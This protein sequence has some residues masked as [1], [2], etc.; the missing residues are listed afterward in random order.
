MKEINANELQKLI[1]D[2]IKIS[3][4]KIN[5]VTDVEIVNCFSENITFTNCIFSGDYM[6]FFTQKD[7]DKGRKSLSFHSCKFYIE[8]INFTSCNFNMILLNGAV[9][10]GDFTITNVDVNSLIFKNLRAEYLE[11][12]NST[13]NTRF[14]L[15]KNTNIG[16]VNINGTNFKGSVEISNSVFREINIEGA[17]CFKKFSFNNNVINDYFSL[18]SNTFQLTNF[19]SNT[20]KSDGDHNC[21]SVLKNT[22]HDTASFVN[23]QASESDL[24][25][26]DCTFNQFTRFN[27]SNFKLLKVEQV[28]FNSISSFQDVVLE[29]IYIERTNFEK[30]SFFDDISISKI[31]LCNKRTLKSIKHE[32][33]R[34]NNKIDFDIFKSYELN[35][36]RKELLKNGQFWYN[37]KDAFILFVGNLFSENGMN[38][39]RALFVTIIGS[40][41]FYT[42]FYTV[43]YWKLDFLYIILYCILLVGY[44]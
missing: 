40:L 11:I 25:L 21:L 7:K 22:F 12:N 36:H 4:T 3:H 32:L 1:N 27:L 13:I 14:I 24:L 39:I 2:E 29:R 17:A 34:T 26:K 19:D 44:K 18:V 10:S 31:A 38:W 8:G 16:H 35:S 23:I 28:N 30:S 15:D 6:L 41:I 9:L 43:Y 20:F 37:N 42:L 5:L 33:L